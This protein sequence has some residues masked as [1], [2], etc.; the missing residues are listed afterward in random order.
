MMEVKSHHAA[1]I[2]LGTILILAM[3]VYVVIFNFSFPVAETNYNSQYNSQNTGENTPHENVQKTVSLSGTVS[4]IAFGQRCPLVSFLV[5]SEGRHVKI[6][7]DSMTEFPI[8]RCEDIGLNVFVR[9]E[10]IEQ[11]DGGIVASLVSLAASNRGT[12]SD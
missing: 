10:G 1:L 2:I 8:G 9:A 3:A 5:Y 12:I 4:S 6:S 11:A 7:A